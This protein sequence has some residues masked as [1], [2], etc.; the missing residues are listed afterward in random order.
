MTKTTKKIQKL[1]NV[2]TLYYQDDKTQAEIARELDV[3]RPLVSRMLKEAKTL[4]IVE[5]KIN[6][7][8]DDE[9][10]INAELI[11]RF[12]VRISAL[13]AER[14]NDAE[15][16]KQI[17]RETLRVLSNKREKGLGIGWGTIMGEMVQLIENGNPPI[18][19]S[20]C[21]LI[22]NSNVSNKNYHSNELVRILSEKTGA[23]PSYL[24]GP[25]FA[26]NSQ[27]MKNFKRTDSFRRLERAWSTM[28]IA[29]VNIGNYPSS[30]DFASA[31]RFGKILA[32]D[33]AV[34]RLLSYFYN[35]EGKILESDTDYAIQIPIHLLKHCKKVVGIC[36][37]NVTPQCLLGAMNTGVLTHIICTE[38]A[39]KASL[40]L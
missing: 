5:V 32:E 38:N 29:V 6:T 10:S 4:G 20:I 31:A 16:N 39:L 15:T 30:P 35:E 34:G 33:K 18:A 9:M 11:D 2:A 26:E 36:S 1:T 19:K 7:V 40:A 25:A 8:M 27:E 23:K 3:S 37:A 12:N 13:I 28:S 21:P 22:G 24:H 14:E 17:A